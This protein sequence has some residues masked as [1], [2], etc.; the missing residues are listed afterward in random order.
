M[1]ELLIVGL[2]CF[3]D[4]GGLFLGEFEGFLGDA[5]DGGIFDRCEGS[6]GESESGNGEKGCDDNAGKAFENGFALPFEF[7]SDAG[8]ESGELGHPVWFVLGRIPVGAGV[9][10]VRFSDL[11][12]QP[13]KDMLFEMRTLHNP[14]CLPREIYP[15]SSLGAVLNKSEEIRSQRSR[16]RGERG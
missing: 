3:G 11:L 4:G 5:G 10:V 14:R 13:A 1:A 9:G 2:E 8:I 12:R 7:G 6:Q 16:G 15:S